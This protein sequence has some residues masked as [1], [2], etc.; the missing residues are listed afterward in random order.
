MKRSVASAATK[1][2]ALAREAE[3][4]AAQ[5]ARELGLSPATVRGWKLRSDKPAPRTAEQSEAQGDRQQRGADRTWEVAEAALRKALAAIE[6]GDTLAAQRLMVSAGI[7][8]DKTGQLEEASARAAE[9]HV[10]LQSSQAEVIVEVIRA[11][12]EALGIPLGESARR[13][14]GD[15]LRQARGG[16]VLVASPVDAEAAAAD[17]REAFGRREL[18]APAGEPTID[19]QLTVD[20]VIEATPEC[21][22]EPVDAEVVEELPPGWVALHQNDEALARR[23]YEQLKQTKLEQEERRDAAQDS[24]WRVGAGTGTGGHLTEVFREPTGGPGVAI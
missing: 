12:A 13:V 5:A 8:A 20:E 4:G 23:A 3:V 22:S 14:L 7:A 15:L 11:F 21:E 17:V 6:K 10:R 1:Q 19:A 9:R 16:G 2:R 18:S 24:G